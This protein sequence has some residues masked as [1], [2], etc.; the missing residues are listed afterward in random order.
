MVNYRSNTFAQNINLGLL[1]DNQH[2]LVISPTV[3]NQND[4]ITKNIIILLND[5]FNTIDSSTTYLKNWSIDSQEKYKTPDYMILSSLMFFSE[6]KCIPNL[7][8]VEQEQ[9]YYKAKVAFLSLNDSFKPKLICIYNFGIKKNEG[10]YKLF[11]IFDKAK[12]KC[13]KKEG[14]YFYF[15]DESNSD[16]ASLDQMI[17]FNNRLSKIF[18]KKIL[19]KYVNIRNVN[20]L[21]KLLGFDF[22]IYMNIPSDISGFTDIDNRIIYASNNSFF[23]PHE[24]VHIYVDDKFK[25]NY[26][27]WFNEGFATFLGGSMGLSFEQHMSTLKY[28]LGT[29][30]T[31]DLNNIL[32]LKMIDSK[33]SYK[34]TIGALFCKIAYEKKGYKGIFNLLSYGSSDSDFYSAIENELGIKQENLNEF[35]RKELEKY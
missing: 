9:D 15:D 27:S 34:Y 30:H 10:D 32:I 4:L 19:F 7:I 21:Y 35:I 31:I 3:Y 29:N 14:C 16:S 25:H 13:I 11:N 23:Y 12:L 1:N 26:H 8:S 18:G 28:N 2:E 33:T 17:E 20:K 24:L 5:Y 22:E 6:Y